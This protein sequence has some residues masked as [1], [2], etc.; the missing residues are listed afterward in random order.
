MSQG[1]TE[2]DGEHKVQIDL[3]RA[4]EQG[5][6]AGKSRI[7]LLSLLEQLVEYTNVH[8]MSEQLLMRLYAYPEISAHEAIHDK[9]M[10]QARRVITDF[11]CDEISSVAAELLLLKQ[12]LLDHIRTDDYAFF[13]HLSS[14]SP[15]LPN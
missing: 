13:V 9:L 5:L 2:M 10:E 6:V 7:E 12:W 4:V 15:P 14:Q 3:I 11:S 8:F 1:D